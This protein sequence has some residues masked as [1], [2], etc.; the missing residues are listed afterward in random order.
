VM[1]VS[2]EPGI[3][4]TALIDAF[5]QQAL[6]AVP[7][8]RLAR[9]QCLEGYGGM[10]AYYP[11]LEALGQLCREAGG[12][13]VVEMLATQAPTWLG[14]FPSL[15]TRAH[16]ET[17]QRELQGAT[18]ERMLREMAGLLEALTADR[19]ALLVFE[20]L[21]WVD[22][23]TVDVLAALARRR[24]PAQLLLV[25]AYRPGDVAGS[26]HPLQALTPDLR[27]HQLCQELAVE[28]LCE[29]DVAAYLA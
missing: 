29:V 6:A 24:V 3:G 5:Q 8:L 25:G 7:G 18:R 23:A 1:F 20:D 4:K 12:A 10:E 13:A 14:Q 22:P 16:R 9:G 11:M 17:L 15:L 19:P 27:V 28:A 2:G 21:Q 26:D